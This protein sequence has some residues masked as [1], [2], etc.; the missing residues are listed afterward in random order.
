MHCEIVGIEEINSSLRKEVIQGIKAILKA[1]DLND[2]AV[3]ISLI[4]EP[5]MLD[6][7][8][9]FK[10][11]AYVTDVL[12]FPLPEEEKN[13][14]HSKNFLGDIVIC[15]KKAES[16]AESFAHSLVEEIAVLTAHGLFHLLGL[17]HEKSEDE[18]SMQ[19]Q[20]EMFLLE[21]AGFSPQL[22]LIGRV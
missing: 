11:K 1:S 9:R 14:A 3:T 21:S 2:Y 7:C 22:S 17:D 8:Q 16:Q 19:M 18:A 15:V 12:S 6:L 4:D 20:G 5:T 10:N 13:F